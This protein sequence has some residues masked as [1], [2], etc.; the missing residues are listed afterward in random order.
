MSKDRVVRRFGA[1]KTQGVMAIVKKEVEL[2]VP[3]NAKKWAKRPKIA[4]F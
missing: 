3:K 1:P 4:C 2:K